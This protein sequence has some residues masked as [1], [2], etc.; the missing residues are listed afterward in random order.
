M[1]KR[2]LI[3]YIAG[4]FLVTSLW[5]C[6]MFKEPLR[7]VNENIPAAFNKKTDTTN[8]S[9]VKW[10]EFFTDK[11]LTALIDTALKNNQELNITLQEIQIARN[12]VKAKKGEYLPFVNVGAGAGA[13]KVGRYTRNGVLEENLEAQ[14][15]KKFS[16]PLG[17]YAVGAVFS[18]ELDVW[19]KLRNSKK[20]AFSRYLAGVEGKNFLVTNLVSEI[21]NSYYELLALDNRLEIIRKN[22]EIQENA[23]SIVKQQKESARVTQL[24]VNRFEA[25]VLNTKNLQFDIQQQIV[26][27]ENRINFLTGRYPTPIIRDDASFAKTVFDNIS[28]GVPTQLVEN[29]PDIRRASQELAATKLDIKVAKAAFY[30][31]L[32]ITASAGFNA[33]NPSLWFNPL[34]ICYSL[35][36]DL[37]SPLINRN[38]IVAN[39]KS[40]RAKQVQAALKYDQ[41]TLNAYLEVRNQL[42][43][44]EN[45]TN[46]YITKNGEVEILTQSISIADN[47]FKSA[48]A[49]Y[50]EV[51]LTQREALESKI[52]LIEIKNKQLKSEINLYKALG[53]GWR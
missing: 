4:I 52:E 53:G 39:Y 34:S 22:I 42:A 46:S 8:T 6:K 17:D 9:K 35:L 29:R 19:K 20:A 25:L 13:D 43:A 3:K 32:K 36:G 31:S 26:E 51:L 2:N 15:G 47:L 27:T 12:E 38:A 45:Y 14:P 37:A 21:A 18:W 50:M 16:E 5:S 44:M 23:L 24:A 28:E 48:R 7:G 1:K 10:R 40:S 49:D 30:P 11:N 33:F 41:T